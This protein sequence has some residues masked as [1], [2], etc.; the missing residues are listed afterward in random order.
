MS[1]R[2]AARLSLHIILY[3]IIAVRNNNM[4]YVHYYRDYIYR[5]IP[6]NRM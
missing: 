3:Y 6:S 5:F 4:R 2:Q 1:R